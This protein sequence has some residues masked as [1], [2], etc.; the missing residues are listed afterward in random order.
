MLTG[1]EMSKISKVT[2]ESLFGSK[3]AL[4]TRGIPCTLS[5]KKQNLVCLSLGES[6]RM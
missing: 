3:E 1:Q 6:E 2:M 5:S 4:K